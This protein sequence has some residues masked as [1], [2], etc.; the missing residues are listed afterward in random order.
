MRRVR[1][2][3]A[4]I[5]VL[6]MTACGQPDQQAPLP[7]DEGGRATVLY[8]DRVVEIARTL[9]DPND[10]WVRPDDL[11]RI[12][13][14]ELKPE[15]ACLEELCIPVRQDRDS[16]IFVTRAGQ[17]WFSVTELARRLQQAFAVDA[18]HAVWSFGNVPVTRNAFLQSAT[19]P[20]FALP[21]REG[22]M[23]RLSDFRG[24][25]VLVITWASW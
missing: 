19:A 3:W 1:Y 17:G 18:E 16:E 23:V 9:T 6:A 20:D 25:K 5:L 13:G 8:Q 10:L 22:K 24:K 7:S 11:P 15:G 4:G 12:N 21:N 14:F 2:T